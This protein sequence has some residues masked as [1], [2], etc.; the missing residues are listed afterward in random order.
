MWK[1]L[2]LHQYNGASLVP[3]L[4]TQSHCQGIVELYALANATKDRSDGRD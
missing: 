2:F 4:K 1:Q 3:L